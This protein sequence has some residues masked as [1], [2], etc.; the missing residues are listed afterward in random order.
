[1]KR[2]NDVGSGGEKMK[3]PIATKGMGKPAEIYGE[4]TWSD[5]VCG[6]FHDPKRTAHLCQRLRIQVL[7]DK[8]PAQVA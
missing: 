1:M 2:R 6:L 4:K 5:S 7:A 3:Y 8:R